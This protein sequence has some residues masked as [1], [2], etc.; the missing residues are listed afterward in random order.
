MFTTIFDQLVGKLDQRFVLNA[1]LPALVFAVAG[2][3]V[4]LAGADGVDA[5][6]AA[7][8]RQDGVV[9]GGVVVLAITGIY[10]IAI[11]LSAL[12]LAIVR[13]F[14][15]YIGPARWF[16]GKSRAWHEERRSELFDT[17]YE[18]AEIYYPPS[19]AAQRFELLPTR[20]GNVL[21]S[22]ERYAYERYGADAVLIWPRLFPL[23]P[24]ERVDSL[25]A[26]RS[27]M[28]QL[29]ILSLLSGL[30]ALAAGP[31]LAISERPLSW[32][33]ACYG[34]GGVLAWALQ[35]AALGFAVSYSSELKATFDL[36][37][38]KVFDALQV[39]A[40]RNR[41]DERR[42]WEMINQ[43]LYRNDPD[44]W[45]YA[46]GAVPTSDKA[47]SDKGTDKAES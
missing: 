32:A 38:L 45:P 27:Q 46:T 37:R 2:L 29:L 36:Y 5:G 24:K 21:L 16:G 41:D 34:S 35:R 3:L 1:L 33:L 4:G 7:W 12:T 13:G 30:F 8:Q 19:N 17:D 47:T 15:G 22:S 40:A 44:G 25:A 23:L 14:E 39:P 20:L 42:R 10:V 9:R 26:P 31:Y 6:V 43:M 28:E 18:Q 11:V